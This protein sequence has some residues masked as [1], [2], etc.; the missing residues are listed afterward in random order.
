MREGDAVETWRG[1]QL[2]FIGMNIVRMA[3]L[4]VETAQIKHGDVKAT[5]RVAIMEH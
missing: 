4:L 2:E 1:Y 5:I 3:I